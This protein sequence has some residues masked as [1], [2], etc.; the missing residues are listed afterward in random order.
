MLFGYEIFVVARKSVLT[1]SCSGKANAD[2]T[3][4]SY[5]GI[6]GLLSENAEHG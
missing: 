4:N 6:Q 2:D 5:V 1:T 3:R